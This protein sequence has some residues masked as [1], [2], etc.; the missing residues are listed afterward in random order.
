MNK[1]RRALLFSLPMGALMGLSGCNVGSSDDA[2]LSLAEQTGE[3]ALANGRALKVN[4]AWP[5]AVVDSTF[6]GDGQAYFI[7]DENLLQGCI[8]G[9][10]LY[11]ALWQGSGDQQRAIAMTLVDLPINPAAVIDPDA[12]N[13]PPIPEGT[14]LYL[15][16]KVFQLA[17]SPPSVLDAVVV[18]TVIKDGRAE[19][20][21][22]TLYD[23]SITVSGLSGLD[24]T[25]SGE[26]T[27]TF[28]GVKGVVTSEPTNNEAIYPL[29]LDGQ[30]R[31]GVREEVVSW[32]A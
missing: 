21:D 12:E 23:G 13:P 22:F 2:S 25:S 6:S 3:R 31:L 15:D 27:L 9:D 16:S 5:Y 29:Q 19:L 30:I 32:L 17:S 20:F 26:I 14:P 10:N 28:S 8:N 1:V 24:E 11:L 18:V 7:P 4:A